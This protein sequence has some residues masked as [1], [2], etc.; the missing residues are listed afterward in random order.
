MRIRS[1]LALGVAA[2]VAALSAAP[3]SAA[4]ATTFTQTVK[5]VT[6]SFPEV[7]ECSGATGTVTITYNGVFH[8][9]ELASGGLHVTGTQTGTFTFVPDDPS[10]PTYT[11]RFTTWFGE[12]VNARNATGTFTF[13][14]RGVG[15]D[16]SVL[17]FH[18]V[19]HFSVSATGV[20]V[21]FDR[22]RCF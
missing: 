10:E 11:G 6:E 13:R 7:N 14:V 17:R 18:Q 2:A 15:S 5:G 3:A 1:L 16:G 19:A 12:N 8:V 9:T 20:T 4:P 21:E 22:T